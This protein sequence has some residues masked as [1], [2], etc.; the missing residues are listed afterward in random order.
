MNITIFQQ[1][2]DIGGSEVF[3][4]DLVDNWIKKGNKVSIY[5]NNSE[6]KSM[7]SISGAK[8]HNLPFTLD[9]TGNKRGFIKSI[10]LSPLALRWYWMKLKGIKNQTD[11]IITSGYAEKLVVTTL[12]KYKKIPVVWLEFPP[13]EILLKRNFAVPK[14]LYRKTASIPFKIIAISN[15]T[16]RSLINQTKIPRDKVLLI[17]PGVKVPSMKERNRAKKK[18]MTIKSKLG[19]NGKRIVGVISRVAKEKGQ[20]KLIR[21]LPILKKKN[22]KLTVILVGRGPDLSRLKKIAKD[23]QIKE[24]VIFLGFVKD[25]NIALAIMDVFAFTATW[26]L[27]GFGLSLVE[28]MMMKIP[29]I[30]FKNNTVHEILRHRKTGFIV[31]KNNPEYLAQAIINTFK[32]KNRS[33]KMTQQGLIS[34]KQ[35]FDIQI[36]ASKIFH[37]LEEAADEKQKNYVDS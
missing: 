19:L 22:S 14:F 34:A 33:I 11:V 5:T 24:D 37:I 9:I 20:E 35:K 4:N 12:S 1:A 17:Y 26:E 30:S 25:K 28:A 6:Y 2:P 10:A 15:N 8:V 18:A 3:V 7:L 29:V 36:S 23:L 32:N 31:R 16:K 21:S 27:E 13:V